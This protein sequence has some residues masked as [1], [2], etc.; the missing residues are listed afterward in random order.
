MVFMAG[1]PTLQE[2]EEDQAGDSE[3]KYYFETISNKQEKILTTSSDNK[4]LDI[5]DLGTVKIRNPDKSVFFR[6]RIR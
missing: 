6:C 1:L 3:L 2:P 5:I 4:G